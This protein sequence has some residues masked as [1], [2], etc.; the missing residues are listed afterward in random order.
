MYEV[1][2][3]GGG[4][5]GMSA[6]LLLG[7]C[8]RRVLVC[9][10]G[11]PRNRA[12]RALNG[13]LS[14]DGIAPEQLRRAAR[15]ELRRYD[16]VE[17]RDVLVVGAAPYQDGFELAL[18][19]GAHE[20]ARKLLLATGVVDE[21]P[22]ISGLSALWGR[23]VFPCPY[24]DAFE[25]RGR[26]LGVL[27]QGTEALAM[28]RALSAWTDQVTLFSNGPAGLDEG[29]CALLG[30]AG[31]ALVTA[32]IEALEASAGGLGR[33]VL[34]G[35]P[36]VAC[37]GLFVSA[38]QHQRSPLVECLGCK[39]GVKGTVGTD[40]H[41]VTEVPGLYLAGDAADE[42]QFAIVA[43]A[44]G[45]MAAFEINRALVRERFEQLQPGPRSPR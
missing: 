13:F 11:A 38:G 41:G 31:F 15:E 1:A 33:I 4:P 8:C 25:L 27:G 42:V 10:A 45:A 34:A 9:D 39:P 7:R 3:V 44:E 19:D 32:R 36:P 5:A 22:P 21:L 37:D 6:A 20:R 43:A 18:A 16:T 26:C 40:R 2:V 23:G 30:A 29:Q 12:S 28:C 14:R 24:C 17:L 35:A